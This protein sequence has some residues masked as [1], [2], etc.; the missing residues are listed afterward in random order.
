MVQMRGDL[1]AGITLLETA[2]NNAETAGNSTFI[3]HS[4]FLH[5][6]HKHIKPPLAGTTRSERS[7]VPIIIGLATGLIL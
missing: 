6:D 3:V 5:K 4:Y 2:N 1:K 7:Q